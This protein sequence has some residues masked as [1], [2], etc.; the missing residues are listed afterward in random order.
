MPLIEIKSPLRAPSKEKL[1]DIS[2]QVQA[3]LKMPTSSRMRL[4][5]DRVDPNTS[6]G[7]GEDPNEH[8]IVIL[9]YTRN[10]YPAEDVQRAMVVLHSKTA[11]AVN[12]SDKNILVFHFP[13]PP[14]TV[15]SSNGLW[16]GGEQFRSM[17]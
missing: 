3:A 11:A 9:F 5:W 10:C 6:V 16:I 7:M 1:I 17:K 15:L 2:S 13:L 14:G 8:Q 4:V 12:V